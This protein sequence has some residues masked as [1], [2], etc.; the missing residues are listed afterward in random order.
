MLLAMT[1]KGAPY[2]DKH[3]HPALSRNDSGGLD[4][5]NFVEITI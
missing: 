5:K 4:G 3:P 2:N 1:K